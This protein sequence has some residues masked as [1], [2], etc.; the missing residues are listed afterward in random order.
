M[1][2]FDAPKGQGKLS[3][4]RRV[5]P[6]RERISFCSRFCC[7]VLGSPSMRE[8]IR[9]ASDTCRYPSTVS[10]ALCTASSTMGSL[11]FPFAQDSRYSPAA[12]T[13][14]STAAFASG[15]SM[16]SMARRFLRRAVSSRR[17]ASCSLRSRFC[18]PRIALAPGF[19]SSTRASSPPVTRAK[20]GAVRSTGA[21]PASVRA[22]R[23]KGIAAHN[24]DGQ[25]RPKELRHQIVHLVA[26]S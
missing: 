22:R 18:S 1:V 24:A 5:D 15:F 10:A 17:S 9:P 3:A 13:S 20:R 25:R 23:Q 7:A 8:P 16:R 6:S 14:R 26:C 4:M 21:I 11:A 2:S 12:N 19:E